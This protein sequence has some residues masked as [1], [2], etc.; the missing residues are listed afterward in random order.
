V[1]QV[2]SAMVVLTA[3]SQL[4]SMNIRVKYAPRA[5]TALKVLLELTNVLLKLTTQSWVSVVS[6]NAVSVLKIPTIVGLARLVA[7]L[8][9]NLPILRK[10]LIAVSAMVNTEPS[11]KLMYHA[12]AVV[13]TITR[14]LM[15]RV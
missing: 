3:N 7:D 6:L 11:L 4:S 5:T 13:D 10:D 9:V 1:N 14:I 8:A 2:I 15:A 12:V